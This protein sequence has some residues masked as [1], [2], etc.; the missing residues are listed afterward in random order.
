MSGM[1]KLNVYLVRHPDQ[2]SNFFIL[3]YFIL[4]FLL[5]SLY[6]NVK[7]LY[8]M[9]TQT[10]S[11]SSNRQVHM[12][13]KLSKIFLRQLENQEKK[14]YDGGGSEPKHTHHKLSKVSFIKG[15]QYR[16]LGTQEL[17]IYTNIYLVVSKLLLHLSTVFI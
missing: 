1:L 13:A 2:I 11:A 9:L 8:T 17:F 6:I 15:M 4:P 16:V 3:F 7:E 12:L 10:S 5:R 14:I